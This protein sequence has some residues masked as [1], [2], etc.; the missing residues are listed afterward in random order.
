MEAIERY[1]TS[2]D[3]LTIIILLVLLL[4]S[5]ARTLFQ[6]RFED[7]TSLGA[8]G[9]YLIIKSKEHKLL[10]GFNI[11]MLTVH[12]LSVSLF[13]FLTFRLF[14][15]QTLENSGNLLLRIITA[16][17]FIVLL[18][19][20]VEKI[21]ANVFDIDEIIDTY[22]FQ[23]QTYLNFISLIIFGL[24]LF[25]VYSDI[26]SL[27]LFY[28]I[29]AIIIISLSYTLYEIIKKNLRLISR[30][31]FYFILYIC[32][33]EIAPYVVLYKLISKY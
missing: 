12:I 19:I 28:L 16:Y 9:K 18:K 26:P 30:F 25:L 10:F 23:K 29:I 17:S 14:T 7:F 4:L 1:I 2:N 8:S 6:T 13:V 20:T 5:L 15:T 3:L 33:L 27:P 32:A 11:L 22:I 21:I 24:S 31:W